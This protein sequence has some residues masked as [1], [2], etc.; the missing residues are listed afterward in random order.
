MRVRSVGEGKTHQTRDSKRRHR[1]C[2]TAGD[3]CVA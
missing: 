1:V 3:V 2:D